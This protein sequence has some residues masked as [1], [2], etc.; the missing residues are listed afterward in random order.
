MLLVYRS[1]FAVLQAGCLMPNCLSVFHFVLA[2]L[3]DTKNK[4]ES[5]M[6][7]EK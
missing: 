1:F 7:A 3:I 4:K 5:K 2:V 6:E